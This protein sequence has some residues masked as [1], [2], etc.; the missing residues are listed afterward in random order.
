MRIHCLTNDRA[1]PSESSVGCRRS[2]MPFSGDRG[3]THF[4]HEQSQTRV[5]IVGRKPS[6]DCWRCITPGE[7]PQCNMRRKRRF[8]TAGDS[9]AK[10]QQRET[11]GHENQDRESPHPGRTSNAP[12]PGDLSAGNV[13]RC[14][15]RRHRAVCQTAVA[16]D[17]VR[18]LESRVSS[19]RITRTGTEDRRIIAS[20]M[21]RRP[22]R[23]RPWRVRAVRAIRS[24]SC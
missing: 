23:D 19:P 3:M 9:C 5:L 10:N 2:T 13:A 21:L 12:I 16:D 17:A 20:S 18:F 22:H 8:A 15:T 14:A 4:G 1:H 7:R 6:G 24:T 11:H